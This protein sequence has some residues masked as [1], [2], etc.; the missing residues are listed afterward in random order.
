MSDDRFEQLLKGYR[1]PDVSADLDRRMAREAARLIER[2]EARDAVAD[3]GR[4]VLDQLGFGYLVW[5]ADVV[6]ATEAEYR[7][8]LI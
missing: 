4:S 7:V 6:T 3:V 8:E 5:A 2:V 1:L